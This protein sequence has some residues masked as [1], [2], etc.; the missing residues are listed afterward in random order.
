MQKQKRELRDNLSATTMIF[1]HKEKGPHLLSY[2]IP[3]TLSETDKAMERC[4]Q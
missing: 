1:H 4:G 2:A 3:K